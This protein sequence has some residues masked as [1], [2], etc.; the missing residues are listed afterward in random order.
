MIIDDEMYPLLSQRRWVMNGSGYAVTWTRRNGKK[1][2][3]FMH[4]LII[5]AKQGEIVDHRNQMKLNNL[6]F[7]LRVCTII[8]NAWNCKVSAT[9]KSGVRGVSWR[10]TSNNWQ[11]TISINNHNVGL[12]HFDDINE[13][14]EAYNKKA[15]E[16]RGEFAR[17]NPV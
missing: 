17:L 13:A 6:R 12:G 16:I 11:V 7:N 10:K 14:A 2:T 15:S 8:E 1:T 4:R 3:L 5:G 9:N